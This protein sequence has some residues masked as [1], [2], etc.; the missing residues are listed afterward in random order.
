VPAVGPGRRASRLLPGLLVAVAVAVAGCG[1]GA[2][3]RAAD[4]APA[5]TS[6]ATPTT[7]AATPEPRDGLAELAEEEAWQAPAD[8][9][10]TRL[11]FRGPV[12]GGDISWPQCPRGMGIPERRSWGAPLPLAGAR[13]VVIGLTNGPGFFANP[14]LADQVDWARRNRLLTAAY[15]VASY[16]DADAVRLHGTDG[17]FDGSTGLGALAN[18]GYQQ[19]RFNVGSMVGAGLRS[20]IVWIDVE[21]VTDFEWSADPVA[22]AAVVHGAARGYADAGYRIGVYSTPYLWAQIVDDL[23]LGVPEW[24]AAGETSRAEAARRCADDWTIQGGEAV[25]AQWLEDERD[26]NVTCPRVHRDLTRWFHSS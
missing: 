11:V 25:L 21:P 6:A 17:P 12:L 22:N 3:S 2:G 16:P 20:P 9:R 13:Y 14:C 1:G 8:P 4:P 5:P 23:A 15:A 10:P 18:T 7:P 26:R 24:R 19:A